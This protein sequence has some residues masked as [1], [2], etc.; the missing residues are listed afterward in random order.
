V[1]LKV[2]VPL[3]V[4][5]L[6]GLHATPT[7]HIWPASNEPSQV[8][9]VL[10]KGAVVVML[11]NLIRCSSKV[12]VAVTFCEG[13]VVPT[14]TLPKARLVG[15]TLRPPS[16]AEAG[17]A[18]ARPIAKRKAKVNTENAKRDDFDRDIDK[19]SRD[20]DKSPEN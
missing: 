9:A 11:M 18:A 16:S 7:M 4:P 15:T 13:L 19:S 10:M 2:S 6:V 3:K 5:A 8:S 12:L 14:A 17:V 1:N 20:I